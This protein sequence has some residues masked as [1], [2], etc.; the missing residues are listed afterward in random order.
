MKRNKTTAQNEGSIPFTRSPRCQRLTDQG[1]QAG[2]KPNGFAEVLGKQRKPGKGQKFVD[3]LDLILRSCGL[4]P[5]HEHIFHDIRKWRFDLAVLDIKL[6]VEYHGHSGFTGGNASGHSTVIGLT[7]D[8]E[9]F[10]QA[11]ILGWTVLAFTTLHFSEKDRLKHKLTS[12]V[13]TIEAWLKSRE[14]R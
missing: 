7:N 6:A 8:C 12:P 3:T 10:N 9:K 14:G 1:G 4:D 11:R 2:D 13:L 5:V